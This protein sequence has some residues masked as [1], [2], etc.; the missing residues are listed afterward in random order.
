MLVLALDTAQGALSAA[1]RDGE[2]ELA[3]IFELRTRGHAEA[4]LPALE[5]LMAEAALGFSDLDA[6]AVTVGPGTFT[7]LRVGLAAARGLALALGLPLVGVTTLEAIAEPAEAKPEEIIVS[8]FDARRN[9]V[10][11]QAFS[12]LHVSL[13][14][15][16]LVGLD[17]VAAHLPAGPLVL[18]GTGAQLLAECLKGR[19]GLRL[20]DARP[21]PDAAAVARIAMARLEAEGLEAFRTAPHPLYLRAPDAKLP[22]GIDPGA[23][24]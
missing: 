15:P 16:Q 14:G 9:E 2:G 23:A 5:T 7:G 21:Q 17:D 24:A 10:Y 8:S 19:A 20:S 12:S 6:L 1:I 13:A 11:L 3:S 22:G 4:L 18:V